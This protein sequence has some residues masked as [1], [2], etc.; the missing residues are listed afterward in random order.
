MTRAGFSQPHIIIET[1]NV[2][3]RC[4]SP[5]AYILPVSKTLSK[6]FM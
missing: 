5:L 6:P 1:H 3:V 2:V 4:Q